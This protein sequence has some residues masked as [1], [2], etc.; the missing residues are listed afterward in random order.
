[1]RRCVDMKEGKLA[2]LKGHDCHILMENLLPIVF[3]ALTE[4]IWKAI[5]EISQFFKQLCSSTLKEQGL[6]RM[7]DNIPIILCKLEKI[8]SPDFF[9]VMEHLP[10]HLVE[11]AKL[12]G[13]VQYR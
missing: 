1:M 7:Q 2:G 6:D 11:E 9:Y 4:N 13:P 3:N 10:I 5:T 8:L 12:S